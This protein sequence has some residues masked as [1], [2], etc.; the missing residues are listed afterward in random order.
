[1]TIEVAPHRRDHALGAHAVQRA[2]FQARDR[3]MRHVRL[4]PALDH[5]PGLETRHV[6]LGL[7]VVSLQR[8]TQVLL[9]EAGGTELIEQS[10]SVGPTRQGVDQFL[11]CR[12][13]RSAAVVEARDRDVVAGSAQ[14]RKR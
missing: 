1:M 9:L 3:L 2:D 10:P 12:A 6:E 8:A 7:E 14:A 13:R 4:V 5:E 11:L